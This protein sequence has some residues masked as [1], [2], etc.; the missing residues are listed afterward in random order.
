MKNLT[1]GMIV[2]V[3]SLMIFCFGCGTPNSK[4]KTEKEKKTFEIIYQ[5]KFGMTIVTM[6]LI[7]D[8]SQATLRSIG[9]EIIGSNQFA[10]VYFYTDKNKVKDIRKCTDALDAMPEDGY[11]AEYTT[12]TGFKMGTYNNN[13]KK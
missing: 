3:G 10:A 8:S 13:Y 6:C 7:S 9:R 4:N 1:F 11:I 5:Q 12:M 2:M